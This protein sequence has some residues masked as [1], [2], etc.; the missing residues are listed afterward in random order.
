MWRV[1]LQSTSGPSRARRGRAACA[2]PPAQRNRKSQYV[3]NGIVLAMDEPGV[4]VTGNDPRS[5][6]IQPVWITS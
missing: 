6:S 4:T 3:G 2:T 1:A 5:T